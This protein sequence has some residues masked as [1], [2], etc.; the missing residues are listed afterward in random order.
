MKWIKI[1]KV[2]ILFLAFNK[3]YLRIIFWYLNFTPW[4]IKVFTKGN[5]VTRSLFD[6]RQEHWSGLLFP[7]PMHESEKWKWSRSVI[8]NSQWPHGLQPIRLLHPWDFLGKSTTVGCHCLLQTHQET[9]LKLPPRV[10]RSPVEAC[11]T[12]DSPQGWGHWQQQARKFPL[13]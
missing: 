11:V 12:R 5:D 3:C 6:S 2:L 10:G 4:K 8:S 13:V 7:S 9:D 1:W